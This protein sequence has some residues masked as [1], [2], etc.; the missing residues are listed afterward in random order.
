MLAP[1]PFATT[2]TAADR[3]P[4]RTVRRLDK[5][6]ARSRPTTRMRCDEYPTCRQ[7]FVALLVLLE[8]LGQSP[9]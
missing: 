3:F 4:I 2:R 5:Q 9:G 1:Q 8:I 6:A 7:L